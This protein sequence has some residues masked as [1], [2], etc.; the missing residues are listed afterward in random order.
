ML[1]KTTLKDQ[2]DAGKADLEGDAAMF[3]AFRTTLDTFEFWWPIVTP[4]EA[5]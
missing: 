2:V 5:M 3:D 4:K 1:G